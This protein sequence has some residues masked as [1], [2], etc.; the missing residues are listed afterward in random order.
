MKNGLTG[1]KLGKTSR[2]YQFCKDSTIF[3]Q[4]GNFSN[5]YQLMKNLK[6]YKENTLDLDV[7]LK[8]LLIIRKPIYNPDVNKYSLSFD[9]T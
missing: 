2:P 5:S 8:N 6:F 1:A 9:Y 7:N 4:N 3:R